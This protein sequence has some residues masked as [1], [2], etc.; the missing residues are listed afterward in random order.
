MLKKVLTWGL[1][2]F[3]VYFVVSRPT[4]AADM[5]KTIGNWIVDMARGF[6]DFISSVVS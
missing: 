6:G 1:V 2:I 5:V 3:L 4:A